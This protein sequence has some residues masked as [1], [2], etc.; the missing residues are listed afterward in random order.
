MKKLNKNQNTNIAE[1]MNVIEE[2]E[3]Y[4]NFKHQIPK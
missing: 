4:K 3:K 1:N 2:F